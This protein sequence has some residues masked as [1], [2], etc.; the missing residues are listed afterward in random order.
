MPEK[1]FDAN[2]MLGP[3]HTKLKFSSAKELVKQ[4][5]YYKIKKALVYHSLAVKHSVAKGNKELLK[6]ISKYK[7]TLYPC[8]LLTPS[9][10]LENGNVYG[11]AQELDKYKVKAARVYPS[12]QSF[13]LKIWQMGDIYA[14]LE[15]KKI[16]LFIP[17]G[18]TNYNDIYEICKNFPKLP[19]V[20]SNTTYRTTRVM[21]QLLQDFDNFHIEI[22]TFVMFNGINDVVKRFGSEKLLFGSYMPFLDPA[23]AIAMVKHAKIS[24]EA[25]QDIAHRNFERLIG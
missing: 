6:E 10:T 19:I 4:M 7:N 13:E 23:R 15:A 1:Y 25:K 21:Y 17:L 5:N 14:L 12:M 24:T 2:C 11:L 20:L 22:S 16:P 9:C 18:E 8:F 3:W